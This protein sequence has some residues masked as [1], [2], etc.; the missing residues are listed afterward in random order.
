MQF[1]GNYLA[2]LR[3]VFP[4]RYISQEITEQSIDPRCLHNLNY[5][6]SCQ[7]LG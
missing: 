1:V 3:L 5:G 6:S 2:L 4:Y 7:N